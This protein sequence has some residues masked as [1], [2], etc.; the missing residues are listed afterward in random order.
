VLLLVC[1]ILW[2]TNWLVDMTKSKHKPQKQKKQPQAPAQY[3]I[4][5]N[6]VR[7][8]VPYVHVFKTFAKGR[9][10][11]R[12]LLEVLLREF[13]SHP[14]EY[15]LNA[16]RHGFVLVNNRKIE[17]NYIFKN[18]DEFYHMTHRHEPA[19][20]GDVTLVGRNK[21]LFAVNKPSSMPMHPC[22]AYRANSML[23][24]LEQ[25]PIVSQQP[26][27]QLVH[28]LDRVTS[29]LVV[30]ATNKKAAH[31]VSEEIRQGDTEK[32]YI[33]RVRGYFGHN[34]N[35]LNKLNENDLLC[36]SSNNDIPD[37]GDTGDDT[38]SSKKRKWEETE[39]VDIT[40][41]VRREGK[42]LEEVRASAGVGIGTSEEHYP[43]WTL[44]RC[45]LSV[46]SHREGIHSCDPNGKDS[47]SCF[48][49]LAYDENSRTSLVLC[50]PVT[51]RTHQLRLHLQ[52]AGNPIANDP[53]YGG[54]LFA[55]EP[56]KFESA[57]L[58]LKR[59]QEIGIEPVSRIPA[60]DSLQK[61]L[62]KREELNKEHD[63][64][65]TVEIDDDKGSRSKT[66]TCASDDA[67]QSALSAVRSD[68]EPL[69]TF[70]GR[71]CRYCLTNGS[72][73]GVN[74][75]R[76]LHCD[77]IWLHALRYR[78]GTDW[79]FCTPLPNWADP[80]KCA[81]PFSDALEA[82]NKKITA[83]SDQTDTTSPNSVVAIT[84]DKNR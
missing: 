15:W 29:G 52:L 11:G 60:L 80:F 56:D 25:E 20:V 73:D 31:R 72:E 35:L 13:G 24:L 18:N 44:L 27:L 54:E 43:G 76:A 28:R 41:P 30:L 14:K 38:S 3:R 37:D 8:V 81:H 70:L 63:D 36:V 78:K 34:L 9:W 47:L 33:A 26:P 67:L 62:N 71:T 79:D 51:G 53:C 48:K 19:V 69:E 50:R 83:V 68:G 32:T 42:P 1:R 57:I 17:E 7:H 6:G 2:K 58:S 16:I 77:G 21:D 12:E 10:V 22:G 65:T 59:L 46:V 5:A 4:D 82:Q 39:A 75:E 23:F 84:E 74:L 49:F 45:P 66:I 61:E 55:E 64:T 40:A